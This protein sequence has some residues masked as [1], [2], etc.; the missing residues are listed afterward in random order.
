MILTKADFK[1]YIDC[2]ESLWLLKN[3]LTEYPKGEFS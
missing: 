3:N 2:P 1:Y